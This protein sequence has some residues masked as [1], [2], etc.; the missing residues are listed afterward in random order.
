MSGEDLVRWYIETDRYDF[1]EDIEIT[2]S[3]DESV[4]KTSSKVVDKIIERAKSK[5]PS[6]KVRSQL[7]RLRTRWGGDIQREVEVTPQFERDVENSYLQEVKDI[8]DDELGNYDIQD[9][10][11][12]LVKKDISDEGVSIDISEVKPRVSN[13][14]RALLKI[15]KEVERIR[16]DIQERIGK[17]EVRQS[18]ITKQLKRE[19]RKTPTTEDDR[20][21]KELEKAREL[22]KQEIKRL[23]EYDRRHY[24]KL[25]K[26]NVPVSI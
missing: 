5:A 4:D 22:G 6:E 7:E 25:V 23:E 15:Q 16:K 3:F 18:D 8:T 2:D 12:E 19:T 1:D 24:R 13:Q 11:K 10:N 26:T 20:L 17:E 14:A 9:E 21:V